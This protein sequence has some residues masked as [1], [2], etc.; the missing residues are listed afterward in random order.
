MPRKILYVLPAT[1][2]FAGIERVTHEICSTLTEEYA[3]LFEIDVLYTS[4]YAGAPTSCNY[5]RIE[6][7]VRNGGDFGRILR[8][9]A[10]RGRYDLIVVPQIEA[11][12][13]AWFACLGLRQRLILC[14]HGNYKHEATHLKSRIMFALMR[15]VVV[16]R[17]AAVFGVSPAQ[18]N[19]F[20]D[21]FGGKAPHY[22]APNPVRRFPLP[23]ERSTEA[24]CITFVKVARFSHQKGQDILLRAFAKLHAVRGDARLVLVGYG[25]EETGLRRSIA[26]LGLEGAARIAHHPQDPQAALSAADVYVSA[27]RWEGWSLAICEA[28]RFGLPVVATDCEFGPR[29]IL[30]D[31]RLGRLTRPM[32]EQALADAML[33]YC[34]TL[35]E[36]RRDAAYRMSYVEKF[37]AETVVHAHAA[38]LIAA[39]RGV[40]LRQRRSAAT[41]HWEAR[42]IT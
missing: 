17:L 41:A 1:K 21:E 16:H 35:E 38:A 28:L 5:N 32:D 2:S 3:D 37:N 15:R 10:R 7:S 19:S 13:M 9:V 20:H 14:L 27:S 40:P 34:D 22:W 11:T 24:G 31:E 12:V 39:A 18:L 42:P 33:H 23:V 4:A 25:A 6:E 30:T 36:A 29:D 26:A 8:R